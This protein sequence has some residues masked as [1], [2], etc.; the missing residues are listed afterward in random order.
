MSVEDFSLQL[1]LLLRFPAFVI[2]L[3]NK[4]QLLHQYEDIDWQEMHCEKECTAYQCPIEQLG[5]QV[6]VLFTP[7][8]LTWK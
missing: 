4:L 5:T 7:R 8:L 6:I 3:S 1:F 2:L